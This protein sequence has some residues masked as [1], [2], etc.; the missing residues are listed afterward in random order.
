MKTG[1]L[2]LILIMIFESSFGQASSVEKNIVYTIYYFQKSQN[3]R[4]KET[5]Y[6]KIT[7]KKWSQS[8]AQAEAI[9]NYTT[10]PKTRL[11]FHNQFSIGWLQSDT[12]GIIDNNKR[13]WIHPPRH[14]QYSLTEIA[15]FPDFRKELHVGDK[16][17]AILLM[18][19]GFGVWANK[20]IK[21]TYTLVSVKK[22]KKDTIWT[23]AANSGFD[24]KNSHSEFIFS[25]QEGFVSITY[26]FYNGD[27]MIMKLIKGKLR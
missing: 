27:K 20:K 11:R 9:W 24:E 6:L 12:T 3:L 19:N 16:Y 4:T 5:I 22:K 13:L 10:D 26:Y 18:G 7:G 15:P 1:M 21:S 17:T 2:F 14:N 25:E 23:I 8:D